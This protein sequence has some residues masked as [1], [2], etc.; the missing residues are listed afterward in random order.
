MIIQL[1]NG[2]I[3]ECSIEVYLDLSD[4]DI[5]ELNG[6]GVQYTRDTTN[7]FYGHFSKDLSKSKI[8]KEEDEEEYEPDLDEID[9]IEKRLDSDFI[10]DDI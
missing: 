6:L 8:S 5:K 1:P 10:P 2:R 4:N 3:I 7:P 9:E